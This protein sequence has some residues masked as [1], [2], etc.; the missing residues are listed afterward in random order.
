MLS[1]EDVR[2]MYDGTLWPKLAERTAARRAGHGHGHGMGGG[3][4]GGGW[5]SSA[6]PHIS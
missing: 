5:H 6:R 4:G 1:K 3:G 2:A